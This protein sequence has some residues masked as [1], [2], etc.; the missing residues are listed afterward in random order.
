M[1]STDERLAKSLI[2]DAVMSIQDGQHPR[3]MQD[4]LNS[5]TECRPM[6]RLRTRQGARA[7]MRKS[8]ARRYRSRRPRTWSSNRPSTPISTRSTWGCDSFASG[9]A[10]LEAESL[11]TLGRIGLLVGDMTGAMGLDPARLMV[12]GHA[13][14]QPGGR[15]RHRCEPRAQ[16]PRRHNVRQR[17]RP[18]RELGRPRNGAPLTG[19][20]GPSPQSRERPRTFNVKVNLSL[21]PRVI[22]ASRTQAFW[23]L[24]FGVNVQSGRNSL[25]HDVRFGSCR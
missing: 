8:S 22:E 14:T 13:D 18:A 12:S 7:S 5:M 21:S 2:I 20:R 11:A 4:L 9:S 23:Q 24:P 10:E 19:E 25:V 6:S 1:R 17:P 16:P 15:E 3:V